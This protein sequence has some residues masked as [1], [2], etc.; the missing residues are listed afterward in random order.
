MKVIASLKGLGFRINRL[1]A[2]LEPHPKLTQEFSFFFPRRL[3]LGEPRSN[4]KN[5]IEVVATTG[6]GNQAPFRISDEGSLVLHPNPI[7]PRPKPRNPNNPK[8]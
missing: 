1:L 3:A 7:D 5:P 8:S 4:P 2:Y 6:D